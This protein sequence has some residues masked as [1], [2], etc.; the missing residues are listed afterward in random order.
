MRATSSATHVSVGIT[1]ASSR[2]RCLKPNSLKAANS[3]DSELVLA[4]LRYT[5]ILETVRIRRQ[6]YATRLL[7]DIFFERCVRG[8]RRW[9]RTGWGREQG[10]VGQ[11]GG[12]GWTE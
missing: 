12:W 4:Q 3:F 6:G 1:W 2:R 7:H 11:G 5:G 9:G 8:G 10:G